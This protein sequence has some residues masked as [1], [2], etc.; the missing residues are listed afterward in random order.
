VR[1]NV[2]VR[3]SSYPWQERWLRRIIGNRSFVGYLA[4]YGTVCLSLVVGEW[5]MVKL[6]PTLLTSIGPFPQGPETEAFFDTFAT[7]AIAAQTGVLGVIS[8]A[9]GLVALIAER[10][11]VD[12]DVGVYYHASLAFEVV[13]SCIALL[14]VLCIQLVWPIHFVG[15]QFIG[16]TTWRLSKFSLL[17]FH[18][19]WL[20][21][22]LT[23]MA[24]F[25][26][27]TLRFVQQSTRED[28]REQYTA[29]SVLPA[30]MTK[31]LRGAIY[32][33]A[34]YSMFS[35]PTGDDEDSSIPTVHFGMNYGEPEIYRLFNVPVELYDVRM[36]L[37]RWAV[38]RWASRC[39]RQVKQS[40]PTSLSN[41]PTLFFPAHL[42][43]P[44]RGRTTICA[45][46]GGVALD[47]REKIALKLAFRFRVVR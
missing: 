13:F 45:R 47:R 8:I 17:I 1:E 39:I 25:V 38:L 15:S 16:E 33:A 46:R 40:N 12:T 42:D 11:G 29:N 3:R 7:S 14:L 32:L 35:T 44:C 21:L 23:A 5:A 19:L 28:L 2:A 10:H 20:V 22:N 34:G 27:T 43:N 41:R 4:I 6:A 26:A 30:E 24:H 31:R 36:S 9:I 18:L 37:V